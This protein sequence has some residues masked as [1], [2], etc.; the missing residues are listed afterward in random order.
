MIG[1][2]LAGL[3]A[4][5]TLLEFGLTV[6]LLEAQP[7][8]GGRIKDIGRNGVPVE[9]GANWFSRSQPL[10][11]EQIERFGIETLVTHDEG[12]HLLSWDNGT[13]SFRGSI[14]PLGLLPLLDIARALA[15]FERIAAR[16][17]EIDP[18]GNGAMAV[19]DH[20][21][22][23]QW[24]DSNLGTRSGREFF[25]LVSEMVFG[26]EPCLVSFLW[27]L[28]Y[29]SRSV[30]LTSLISVAKGHQEMR[31]KH[32]PSELCD[33]L[34]TCIPPSRLHLSTPVRAVGRSATGSRVEVET[35]RGRACYR[36]VL[37]ATAPHA[38]RRIDF[39]PGLPPARDRLLQALPMGRVIKVQ[40]IYRRPFWLEQGLSGQVMSNGFPLTYTIDNSPADRSC[41][42]LAGFVC[43]SRAE[44]FLKRSPGP[45][46]LVRS[47]LASLF[48]DRFPG[49]EE[50]VIEDW[51]SNPWVGG[52]YGAY[53]S[54]GVM[55]KLGHA[56]LED[57]PPIY[58]CGAE[59]ARVHPCQMEGALESGRR[60]GLSIAAA[61]AAEP[62]KLPANAR[63]QEGAE[64]CLS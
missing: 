43:S 51:A 6:D 60:V 40:A 34:A 57:S 7:S 9:L 33:R 56:V 36:A 4:A 46:A 59:L 47:A 49:P 5:D 63:H 41:G 38:A 27:V 17:G 10:M 37:C 45:E 54:P 64:P 50:I 13:R 44:Q 2:G 62:R 39:R 32:G 61:L 26:V 31:F 55:T 42:V 16:V 19:Y 1:A 12:D 58:W 30:S 21:S 24:I 22:F 14:P 8:V 11:A 28:Y 20:Q 18:W 23:G 52:S 35:P 3:I 53:W 25:R 15:R 29:A 48:Q